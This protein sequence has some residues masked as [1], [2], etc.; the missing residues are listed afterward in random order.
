[1]AQMY[2]NNNERDKQYFKVFNFY[3]KKKNVL[4]V[5]IIIVIAFIYSAYSSSVKEKERQERYLEAQRRLA[6]A[7]QQVTDN[8]TMSNAERIQAMLREK[9]GEPPEGF[10]WSYTGELIPLSTDELSYEDVTYTYVRSLSILDFATAQRVASQSYVIDTYNDYYGITSQVV[11]DY[12][13]NF[14]RKQFK[15]SLESLE[16]SSIE[17]VAIFANGDAVMTVNIRC[18]DLTDKDFWQNDMM[19]MYEMM[20]FYDETEMDSIKKESYVYDYIYNA[21]L[22]G[23]IGKRD[24]TLDL[25]VSK[26]NGGGW[27]ISDDSELEAALSYENGV[28][29]ASYIMKLYSE[30]YRDTILNENMVRDNNTPEPTTKPTTTTPSDTEQDNQVSSDTQQDIDTP[31]EQQTTPTDNT[32]SDT[33]SVETEPA[34]QSNDNAP[35][36]AQE[37]DEYQKMQERN[38]KN[39]KNEG[40]IDL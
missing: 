8:E 28:D 29:V 17:D 35:V 15:V 6:M 26:I 34:L 23:K 14:L 12:Y 21:Y 4:I 13:N 19:E 11:A 27:L 24:V 2:N 30:W 7:N 16:I 9:Y 32:D 5:A 20:R 10:E 18:L 38:E 1:M 36:S 33:S 31:V 39:K 3:I 22:D 25:V 37:P 40:I